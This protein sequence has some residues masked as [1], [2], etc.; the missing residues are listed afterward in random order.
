ME[1]SLAT[2]EP[3]RAIP[4]YLNTPR[5]LEAC[6]LNGVNPIELIEVPITDF[7]K[8][9]PN[10]ADAVQ[11]RFERVDG[12]RR[13][14]LSSVKKD[15]KQLCISGWSKK[16]HIVE[17]KEQKESI[18]EVPEEAHSTL[19]EMQ[20]LKFRKIEMEQFNILQRKLKLQLQKADEEQKNKKIIQKHNEIQASNDNTKK[21]QQEYRE[22]IEK[23]TIEK[24]KKMEDEKMLELK[25]LRDYDLNLTKKKIKEDAERIIKEKQ[26]KEKIEEEKVNRD[27]Y[28]KQIKE[29]I[30]NNFE[31]KNNA[32]K[33]ILEIRDKNIKERLN[34]SKAIKEKVIEDKRKEMEFKIKN[35]KEEALRK[36][37]EQKIEVFIFL[38]F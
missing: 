7:Q 14:I 27:V 15:W 23:E 11:R 21:Q 6:R 13:R 37:E 12:A 10:D 35:A 19:L 16:E 29:S 33:K 25:K 32:R 38:V 4:P 31:N 28:T 30:L 8:E 36:S 18:V 1:L 2:F 24:T 5:S 9:F 22:K 3:D 17:K 26:I 20:A 34:E